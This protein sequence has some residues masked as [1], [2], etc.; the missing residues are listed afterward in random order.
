SISTVLTEEQCPVVAFF[1]REQE[2][3]HRA[4]AAIDVGAVREAAGAPKHTSASTPPEVKR[5]GEPRPVVAQ[6]SGRDGRDR[7]HQTARGTDRQIL[8]LD[9][10]ELLALH[11]LDRA[12]TTTSAGPPVLLAKRGTGWA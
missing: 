9:R 3:A 8:L 10:L 12:P 5:T 6:I 2:Q 1:L 7:R 11:L 4:C